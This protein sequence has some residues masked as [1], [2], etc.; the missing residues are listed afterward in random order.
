MKTHS[1]IKRLFSDMQEHPEKYSDEQLEA[2]MA[3]LDRSPDAN[4]AW[5][6]WEEKTR[7]SFFTDLRS[8][9][10]KIAASFLAVAFLG[11]LSFAGY[12]VISE[13]RGNGQ[14]TVVDTLSDKKPIAIEYLPGDTIYRFENIRLDSILSIVCRHYGKKVEFHSKPARAIR[15]YT[16]W[17]STQAL[18]DFVDIMNEFDGLKLVAEQDTLFV[19]SVEFEECVQ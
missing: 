12:R 4:A 9:L 2:M 1:D 11:V 3:D 17:H 14:Q 13:T 15:L 7:S 5:K 10:P 18:A 19:E 16:T 8:S 6:N